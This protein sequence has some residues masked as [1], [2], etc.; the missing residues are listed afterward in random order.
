MRQKKLMAR[1]ERSI[2]WHEHVKRVVTF[3]DQARRFLRHV[4][5][6][7]EKGYSIVQLALKQAT[8]FLRR[9]RRYLQG[10]G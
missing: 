1:D 4:G 8:D 6:K 9:S 2:C 3:M 10:I 5:W 7:S